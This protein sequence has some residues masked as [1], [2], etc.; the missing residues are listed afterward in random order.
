M[1]NVYVVFDMDDS[2]MGIYRTL[3]GAK[4]RALKEIEDICDINDFDES[5]KA[6]LISELNNHLCIYDMIYITHETLYD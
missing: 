1:E 5:E 2:I 3:E 6:H 4:E